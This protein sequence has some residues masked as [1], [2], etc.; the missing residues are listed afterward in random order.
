MCMNLFMY[1]FGKSDSWCV[2]KWMYWFWPS[3]LSL[4]PSLCV[5]VCMRL[6]VVWF[7]DL[8]C[9]LDGSVEFGKVVGA[10][11]HSRAWFSSQRI[12]YGSFFFFKCFCIDFEFVVC[13]VD[14]KLEERKKK[15]KKEKGNR[16][17]LGLMFP[18][19][20]KEC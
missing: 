3:S 1:V 10:G 6:C 12:R 11:E 19:V 4:S 15:K 5:Y 16:W 7:A 17:L 20:F 8:W 18:F 13:L 2:F 9:V 14:E